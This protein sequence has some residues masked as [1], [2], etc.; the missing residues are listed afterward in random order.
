MKKVGHFTIGTAIM[1]VSA[2]VVGLGIY[3]DKNQR[4]NIQK[5]LV[6]SSNS[7]NKIAAISDSIIKRE[8]FLDSIAMEGVVKKAHFEGQQLLRDSIKNVAKRVK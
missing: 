4:N 8:I 6:A 5:E 3:S 1:F 7:H 2:S